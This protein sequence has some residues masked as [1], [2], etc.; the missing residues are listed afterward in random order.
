VTRPPVGLDE[1]RDFLNVAATDTAGDEERWGK[2]RAATRIVETRVGAMEVRTVT[3]RVVG[4]GGCLILPLGPV[5]SVT[6]VIDIVAGT[7]MTL[8]AD[9]LDAGAGI[10]SL[11]PYGMSSYRPR[12]FN[13]TYKIG[14]V[15]VGEHLREATMI[16]AEQLWQ[17]QRTPMMIQPRPGGSAPAGPSRAFAWPNRALQLIEQDLLPGF[18]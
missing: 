5:I 4:R 17:S 1:F 12:S 11:Y 16:V 2:L 3:S 6:S 7:T 14:R 10:V 8:Q 13:V 9:A 18:A 15:P